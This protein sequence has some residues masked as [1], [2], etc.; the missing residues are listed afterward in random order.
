[1]TPHARA[2]G[3]ITQDAAQKHTLLHA[4]QLPPRQRETT[5]NGTIQQHYRDECLTMV[6]YA[7][8]SG[9]D[10]KMSES[11]MSVIESTD[12]RNIFPQAVPSVM[13]LPL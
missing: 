5:S 10:R 6:A 8:C 9:I 2:S 3:A 4:N 13:L 12:V 1:M 11:P 7:A